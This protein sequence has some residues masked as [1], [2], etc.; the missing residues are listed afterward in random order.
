MKEIN[1]ETDSIYKIEYR[2]FDNKYV[3]GD[4]EKTINDL[5]EYEVAERLALK[6]E[7][8]INQILN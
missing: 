2:Q 6:R 8:I 1:N 3:S 7:T 5:I 4:W